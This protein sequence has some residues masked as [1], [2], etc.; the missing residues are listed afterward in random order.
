MSAVLPPR[1]VFQ[2]FTSWSPNTI[3][4]L[5]EAYDKCRVAAATSQT[6]WLKGLNRDGTDIC[7]GWNLHG[8]NDCGLVD[9]VITRIQIAPGAVGRDPLLGSRMTLAGSRLAPKKKRGSP[10]VVDVDPRHPIT[11]QIFFDRLT[12]GNVHCGFAGSPGIRSCVRWPVLDRNLNRTGGLIRAGCAA[13]LWQAGLSKESLEWRG[14]Q[15]SPGLRALKQA[16]EADV[17]CCGLA[18]RFINYRTLYYQSATWKGVRLTNPELLSAAYRDGFTGVNP[19]LSMTIG[20]IGVWRNGGLAT[21]PVERLLVPA[22]RRQIAP[23]GDD[24]YIS[25]DFSDRAPVREAI[26][27]L[28]PV[29]VTLDQKRKVAVLDCGLT[30]PERDVFLEKVDLGAFLLQARRGRT[31]VPIGRPITFADYCRTAYERNAGVIEIPLDAE[32]GTIAESARLELVSVDG[33]QPTVLREQVLFADSEERG[34]YLDQAEL[35]RVAIDV[36]ERGTPASR[37]V[38]LKFAH[39]SDDG[40][41]LPRRRHVVKLVDA[42]GSGLRH[43]RVKVG[44]GGRVVV[45]LQPIRP[46]FCFLSFRPST[47]SQP[48]M[49]AQF[50][51]RKLPYLAVRVLPF[52]DD[53]ERRTADADLTFDFIYE[54]V[55]KVYD[56]VYPSMSQTFEFK[57]G[58]LVVNQA[59]EIRARLLLDPATSTEY[60]P[61]SRDLSAG[62]RR[63]LLRF[64]ELGGGCMLRRNP[65]ASGRIEV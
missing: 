15:R 13:V 18:I 22:G 39:Y 31:F 58:E 4:N 25:P 40:E 43:D 21:A 8:G 33:L 37:P 61:A 29:F 12:V 49:P 64:L 47:G 56:V 65:S 2:G 53:L 38:W 1:L 48:R 44:P 36:F 50:S 52:D 55:L 42:H 20:S 62:K 35:H 14:M 28:G 57:D 23:S 26:S 3:N 10:C 16:V 11:A 24:G 30:F 34:I 32:A 17:H 9:V 46:G 59:E 45:G 51:A 54:R 41:P 60:L 5:A 19:A 7:G 63:L 6:E 27:G